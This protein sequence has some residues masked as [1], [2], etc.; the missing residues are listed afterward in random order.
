[1]LKS[2]AFIPDL[3]LAD[4]WALGM[5][6]FCVI[7]SSLKFRYR[8][9]IRSARCVSSPEELKKFICSLFRQKKH[10]LPD[11]NYEIQRATVYCGLEDVYSGCVNFERHH[12]MPL[13]EAAKILKR[14]SDSPP[15]NV[16]VVHLNVSQGTGI[17]NFDENFE[18]CQLVSS[19]KLL[20]MTILTAPCN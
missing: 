18:E 1:M 16:H 19:R 3:L 12:R 14:S 2:D 7:N 6:F 9:E 11:T 5:I 10:P 8:S 20:N 4:L 17:E 15:E 13:K